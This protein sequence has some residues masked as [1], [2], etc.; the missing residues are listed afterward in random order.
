MVK[1]KKM[2]AFCKRKVS[3]KDANCIASILTLERNPFGDQTVQ[4]DDQTCNIR[5]SHN[6]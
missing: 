6:R 3:N 5:K 4:L 2:D 1:H